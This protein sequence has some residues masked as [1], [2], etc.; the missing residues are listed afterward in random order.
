M[1]SANGNRIGRFA[2][3]FRQN[4]AAHTDAPGKRLYLF[5]ILRDGGRCD[6]VVRCGMGYI[7]PD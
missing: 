2:Y 7:V 6:S 1:A 5:F 3:D 4:F